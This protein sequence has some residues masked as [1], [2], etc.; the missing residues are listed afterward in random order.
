LIRAG[1]PGLFLIPET[2]SSVP[3]LDLPGF[4]KEVPETP[5]ARSPLSLRAHDESFFPKSCALPF[6]RTR[7]LRSTSRRGQNLS[8]LLISPPMYF[9]SVPSCLLLP[10]P[11]RAQGLPTVLF[12]QGGAGPDFRGP[13]TGHWLSDSSPFP[14][15]RPPYV[16]V[17]PPV[18]LP[19]LVEDL[20]Y[21]T[22]PLKVAGLVPECSSM[23]WVSGKLASPV[24]NLAP[25][26]CSP[27]LAHPTAPLRTLFLSI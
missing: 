23:A 20:C 5:E 15:C 13:G 4:F 16:G 1:R 14:L 25:P 26:F 24:F 22:H 7:S 19:L 17:G 9:P 11:Q 18:L 27:L 10:L 2:Y 6:R 21:S 3:L 12:N 8:R